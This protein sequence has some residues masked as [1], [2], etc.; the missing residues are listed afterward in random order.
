MGKN[1][2]VQLAELADISSGLSLRGAAPISE[3]GRYRM[4][5]P[6]DMP[7]DLVFSSEGLPFCSLN[8]PSPR[9][10]LR[11]GD[12]VLWG[13]GDLRC[14]AYHGPSD[15]VILAGPLLRIR[16][17]SEEVVPA[18]LALCLISPVVVAQLARNMRGTGLQFVSRKDIEAIEIVIPPQ[19]SQRRIIEYAELIR[20]EA[21]LLER[22]SSLRQAL[23][24]AMLTL[25]QDVPTKN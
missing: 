6:G 11:S 21:M 15:E 24:N 19:Q 23:I 4:L 3:L 10:L 7:R 17:H 22:L 14:G 2:R 13:R 25:T 8:E 1:K 12:L 16:P 18:F 5:Q 9:V 20:E